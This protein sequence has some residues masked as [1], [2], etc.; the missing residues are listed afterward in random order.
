MKGVWK[1]DL[2]MAT[3]NFRTMLISG[4]MQEISK[5]MMKFKID[6][7]ALQGIQ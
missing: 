7:I 1:S 5:E 2:A 3:W 6:I 4:K